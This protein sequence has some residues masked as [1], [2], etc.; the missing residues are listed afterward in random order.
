MKTKYTVDY[1]INKFS[2]IPTNKWTTGDYKKHGRYCALGHA[3]C[4]G[5]DYGGVETPESN[6]LY[7][8]FKKCDYEVDEVN[9]GKTQVRITTPDGINAVGVA[10]CSRKENFWRKR[11]L[12]IAL[13]RALIH[14]EL[15]KEQIVE[16]KNLCH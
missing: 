1:F 11:G 14:L 4:R 2:R 3:G 5:G 16:D 6:A 10:D 12:N 9:G 7:Y 15:E 13:G 8:M